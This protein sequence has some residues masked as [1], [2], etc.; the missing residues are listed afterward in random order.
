MNASRRVENDVPVGQVSA[1]VVGVTQPVS[2][3]TLL[4]GSQIQFV[5]VVIVLLIRFFPSKQD[6]IAFVGDIRIAD[7]AMGI[8]D[9]VAD[10][11]EQA[12]QVHHAQRTA[13]PEVPLVL[14]VGLAFGIGV[15]RTAHQEVLR[16][17]DAL[18]HAAV[19]RQ[20]GRPPQDRRVQ[21]QFGPHRIV[22]LVAPSHRCVETLLQVLV[23]G[24]VA[25]D[26]G[27]DPLDAATQPVV[28][29]FGQVFNRQP[30]R[31]HSPGQHAAGEPVL[32]PHCQ[33]KPR[34][35][36][37]LERH[38]VVLIRLRAVLAGTDDRFPIAARQIEDFPRFRHAAATAAR[39][40]IEPVDLDPGN[41]ARFRQIVLHPLVAALA[42]PP[43]EP[44]DGVVVGVRG[45][46]SVADRCQRALHVRCASGN[47][48]VG[49]TFRHGSEIQA[50]PI[51]DRFQ[52]QPILA[53]LASQLPGSFLDSRCIGHQGG[54][55]GS[56]P[57]P[58]SKVSGRVRFRPLVSRLVHR[59]C[60][61]DRSPSQA[62][63]YYRP[64]PRGGNNTLRHGNPPTLSAA[65]NK[66]KT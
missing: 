66:C 56:V 1:F 59:G 45:Q 8:F 51:G 11:A 6:A 31:Q 52:H 27:D 7:D 36:H 33:T 32:E 46:F 16:E 28:W 4:A 25:P 53:V 40:V 62:S 15:V 44:G 12:I 18:Q 22:G 41:F 9:Q 30:L 3:W 49:R 23:A 50:N 64:H 65:R 60:L 17:H 19:R 43:R 57:R 42:I 39:P 20:A 37:G 47:Q 35:P 63:Q 26:A 21:V 61:I 48:C 55:Q 10:R 58:L 14:R 38:L 24:R 34:C 2:Q 29:C 13:G 54:G 5:Q